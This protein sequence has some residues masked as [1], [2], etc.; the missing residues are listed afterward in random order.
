MGTTEAIGA[1]PLSEL[2]TPA[3]FLH[4]GNLYL[5]TDTSELFPGRSDVWA[6]NMETFKPERFA[7]GTKVIRANAVLQV[8]HPNG[9]YQSGVWEDATRP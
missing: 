7:A 1:I 9:S 6:V 4:S 3:W 8:T 5:L 2:K